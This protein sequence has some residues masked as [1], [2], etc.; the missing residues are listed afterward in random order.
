M[1]DFQRCPV[2]PNDKPATGDKKPLDRVF[3]TLMP[4][5]KHKGTPFYKIP[6]SYLEWLEKELLTGGDSSDKAS[7]KTLLEK[8]SAER[9]RRQ[10][11]PSAR[12]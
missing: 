10:K 12:V 11:N 5:G 1:A 3:E 4:W 9:L 7:V 8:V 2:C 6:C